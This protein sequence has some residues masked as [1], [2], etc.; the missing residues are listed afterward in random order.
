LF[1]TIADLEA[2]TKN[3]YEPRIMVLPLVNLT[4]LSSGVI[5]LPL[6]NPLPRAAGWFFVFAGQSAA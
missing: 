2:L 3:K 5:C 1:P 4:G 6:A